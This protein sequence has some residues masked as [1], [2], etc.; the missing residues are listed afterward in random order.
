MPA[1]RALFVAT[2]LLAQAAV[3]R[4]QAPPPVPAPDPQA[5]LRAEFREALDSAAQPRR[6]PDGDALRGYLLF[7]YVEA[8]RLR[9]A[10]SKVRPAARELALEDRVQEFLARHGE[11]PVTRELRRH[12]LAYLGDRKVWPKFLASAPAA[13]TETSLRCHA[14]AA[15]MA[16]PPPPGLREE[17]LALWATHRERPAA[18]EP[19]FQWLDSP[20]RLSPAEIVERGLFAARHRL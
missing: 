12:W 6:A 7:P 10:L 15:R 4:A 3:A 5:A 16:Q 9:G 19:V 20:E 13:L 18:C 14:L 2:L 8:A 1:R 17:A 11:D